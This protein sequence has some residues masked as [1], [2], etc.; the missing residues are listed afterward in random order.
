M[1]NT[2]NYS[3]HIYYILS[4]NFPDKDEKK[5]DSVDY[6]A[7]LKTKSVTATNTTK[8]DSIDGQ[9]KYI[10]IHFVEILSIFQLTYISSE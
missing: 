9:N 6:S 5:T 1:Y 3:F 8:K 2:E 10:L 4:L 7:G